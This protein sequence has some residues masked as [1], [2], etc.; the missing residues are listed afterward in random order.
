MSNKVSVAVANKRLNQMKKSFPSLEVK[1]YENSYFDIKVT[2]PKFYF[3]CSLNKKVFLAHFNADHGFN[4]KK[5][6]PS[7]SVNQYH[8]H[9]ATLYAENFKDFIK[10]LKD[11][12]YSEYTLV[13]SKKHI[14]KEGEIVVSTRDELVKTVKRLGIPSNIIFDKS[15]EKDM[16]F[17]AKSIFNYIKKKPKSISI[18]I[19]NCLP[20]QREIIHNR[21][22]SLCR[23]IY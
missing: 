13:L 2:F 14:T 7:L 5:I 19:E 1:K 12:C 16:V 8:R 11:I 15:F 17:I 18:N 20:E 23:E 10:D 3:V 9:I 21:F 6:Y 4:F 22:V